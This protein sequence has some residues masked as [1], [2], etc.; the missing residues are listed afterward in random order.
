MRSGSGMFLIN[1][2]HQEKYLLPTIS[3]NAWLTRPSFIWSGGGINRLGST[4]SI[5]IKWTPCL[6]LAFMFAFV[7]CALY[8]SINAWCVHINPF[9][10][11]LMHAHSLKPDWQ[12]KH[13]FESI[14]DLLNIAKK[15]KFLVTAIV[16]FSGVIFCTSSQL[17]GIWFEAVTITYLSSRF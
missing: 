3:M 5:A 2:W 16:T 1:D 13:H 7:S 17:G 8:L 9:T 6:S 11:L 10:C 14:D 4:S 15:A 12:R